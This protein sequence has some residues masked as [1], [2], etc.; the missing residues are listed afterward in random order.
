M[1]KNC[2]LVNYAV[3]IICLL[4]L[5]YFIDLLDHMTENTVL[6]AL[7]RTV[8]NGIH[9][10][11]LAGWCTTLQ[12]RIINAQVRH[13]LIAV[14]ILM[15][16]WLTA[17][18]VKYEFI[19]SR[20]FWL[21]RYIWYSY[22]IPMILIPL[23]GFFIIDH[24]GK[25]EGY[26][27]PRRMNFL[28]IPALAILAGI[29]TNDL[30]QLA[31][32]FPEGIELFDST[33]GYGPIFFLSMA[34]FV[35]LGIYFVIQLLKKS[36]VPGQKEMQKLPALI[37]GGAVIFWIL[38]CLGI[39]RG[40]DLTVADC[41]IISLLLESAIQSGL[42][43]SNINYDNLFRVSTIAA[44]IT[45]LNYRVC[46]ASS[47]AME[48]T[49]AEM[50]QIGSQPLKSGTVILHIKPVKSGFVL[51]Q[52]DVT[53]LHTM[54]EQLQNVQLQLGKENELLQKELKLKE[55]QAQLEEKKRIYDR[56]AEDMSP[57]LKKMESLL[58][59]ASDPETSRGAMAGICVIGSYLKR[60]SN[61]LLLREECPA[62]PAREM[63]YCLWE[64]LQN[65]QMGDVFTMLDAHC[66][67]NLR[68]EDVIAAYDFYEDVVERLL[69]KMN[70]ILVHLFCSR[71]MMKMKMQIGCTETVDAETLKGLNLPS[72]SFRYEI[73]EKDILFHLEFAEGGACE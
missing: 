40:V 28:Y 32:T 17:K 21:G 45:D 12:R 59:A 72:G 30:H 63:E 64:S 25:P 18:V 4:L 33:Y 38:Y 15:G 41:L 35:L 1:K 70:A 11:L 39:F 44:Q 36:R 51:W 19:A 9:I 48:L 13:R 16:F 34:W 57:K 6:Q 65:L 24:I 69:G 42:I 29:F 26:R 20:I 50:R 56:I 71:Q 37:M 23:M 3:A 14:S 58:E 8:R 55:Q 66:E 68:M 22:Y 53:E 62:V 54:M 46:F 73:Q 27:N 2:H 31:F 10:S 60:R 49:E 67:G 7:L 5:A 43:P 47:S 61:L 52:D